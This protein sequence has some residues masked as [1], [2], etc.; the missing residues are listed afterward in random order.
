VDEKIDQTPVPIADVIIP[1]VDPELQLEAKAALTPLSPDQIAAVL[2]I[3]THAVQTKPIANKI[4]YLRSL[5]NA[6]LNGTLSPP[7]STGSSIIETAADRVAKSKRQ[8]EEQ[9]ERGKISN[10]EYFA[11]MKAR[12]GDKFKFT[13]VPVFNQATTRVSN[14]PLEKEDGHVEVF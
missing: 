6:C 14:S 12:F 8:R 13:E 3:F 9:L 2:A 11:M 5:V 10:A 7:K 1:A 4:G